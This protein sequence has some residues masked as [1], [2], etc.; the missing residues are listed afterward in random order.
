[1]AEVE[2]GCQVVVDHDLPSQGTSCPHAIQETVTGG[3]NSGGDE[4]S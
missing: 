1:M 2:L 4:R 3:N